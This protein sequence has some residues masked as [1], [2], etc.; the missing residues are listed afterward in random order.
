MQGPDELTVRVRFSEYQGEVFKHLEAIPSNIARAERIRLLCHIGLLVER[1][2]FVGQASPVAGSPV[3]PE[4]PQ[5]KKAPVE[6]AK[7]KKKEPPP[8]EIAMEDVTG[9]FGDIAGLN[10]GA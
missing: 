5:A 2:W 6:K 8:P 10:L 1:G 9:L 3:L 4:A 7:E